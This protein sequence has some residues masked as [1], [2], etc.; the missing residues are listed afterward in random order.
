MVCLKGI[1]AFGAALF[2]GAGFP[3]TL[4]VGQGL[5]WFALFKKQIA[6]VEMGDG[7]PDDLRVPWLMFGAACMEAA[8]ISV[9]K[10]INLFLSPRAP[11]SW[12][13]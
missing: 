12:S 11:L 6:Y 5:T 9:E 10:Y 7:L 3:A 8:L 2:T 4:D 1:Q 13:C